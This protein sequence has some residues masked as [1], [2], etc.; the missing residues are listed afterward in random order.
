METNL[1]RKKKAHLNLWLE[2]I[3]SARCKALA[4][5]QQLTFSEW[6]RQILRREVGKK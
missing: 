3:L 5:A 1:M 2:P 4:E 6:V